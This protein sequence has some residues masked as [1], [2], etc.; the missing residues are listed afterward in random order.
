MCRG[1]ILHPPQALPGGHPPQCWPHMILQQ[2]YTAENKK[3]FE[4]WKKISL[5][6]NGFQYV[7]QRFHTILQPIHWHIVINLATFNYLRSS[8]LRFVLLLRLQTPLKYFRQ[9]NWQATSRVMFPLLGMTQNCFT[10]KITMP[11][12]QGHPDIS[13]K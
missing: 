12:K 11:P 3:L 6:L 9:H 2:S 7:F 8:P 10:S 4:V 1:S 5:L 13:P